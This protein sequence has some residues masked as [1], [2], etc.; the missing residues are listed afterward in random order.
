MFDP[1]SVGITVFVLIFLGWL[2][3]PKG[4][5]TAE[6][7][8]EAVEEKGEDTT[9]VELEVTEAVEL[10]VS[11]VTPTTKVAEPSPRVAALKSEDAVTV[12][13]PVAVKAPTKTEL[14]NMTKS[15]IEEKAKEFGFDLDRR[16]TKDK[17]IA[18]FQKLLKAKAK[19]DKA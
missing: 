5:N 15:A 10:E 9:P 7:T 8:T 16:L 14:V 18:E 3:I 12:S 6:E 13:A 19:A 11:D 17:M 2:L 4:S 1:I